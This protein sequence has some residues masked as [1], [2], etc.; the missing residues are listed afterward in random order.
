MNKLILGLAA[1][2]LVAT[3]ATAQTTPVMVKLATGSELATW[4][5]QGEGAARHKTPVVFLHGGPGMFTTAAQIERGKIL[6]NAGFDTI[7]YDQAGGGKSAR[8]PATDY[9]LA[10]AV[11]DLEA[12]RIAKGANKLILWGNSYGAEL[13]VIYAARHPDR[14]AGFILTS[15]GVYPGLTMSRDYGKTARGSVSLGKDIAAAAALI[16]KK[17]AAAEAT[18]TQEAAGKMMDTLI[19]S[20][21]AGAG[22]CKGAAAPAAVTESGGN[23]FANRMLLKELKTAPAPAFVADSVPVLIIRG[24]CDYIPEKSLIRYRQLLG[25]TYV[26]VPGSGHA[27]IENRT[28][29]DA[30]MAR[31]ANDALAKVE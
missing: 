24:E 4:T 29:I 12:L 2:S 19:Q 11:A 17:G 1:L 20:E 27:L 8:I 5:L 31:F 25:G 10:R 26:A 16:D 21:W 14:V 23:L 9:T 18:L 22:Q 3:T 7:Y 6:R 28:I 15:P 13:A 30:T